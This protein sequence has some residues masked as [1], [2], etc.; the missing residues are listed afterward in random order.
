MQREGEFPPT[1]P[2]VTM[3]PSIRLLIAASFVISPLSLAQERESRTPE[4]ERPN[5]ERPV[6]P[7]PRGERPRQV[8][9]RPPGPPQGDP[10]GMMMRQMEAVQGMMREQAARMERAQRERD[11][12]MAAMVREMDARL[13]RLEGAAKSGQARAETKPNA[14]QDKHAERVR[15]AMEALEAKA[16]S[17]KEREAEMVKKN[18]AL[19]R[20]LVV[21]KSELQRREAV[22]KAKER[23]LEERAKRLAAVEARLREAEKG[24][25]K[26]RREGE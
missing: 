4:R 21:E 17:M 1:E 25:R 12:K 16:R 7:A 5:A 24:A 11:E 23:E 8:D 9:P 26:E 10:Q 15:N 18:E 2:I 14:D 22:L 20:E 3:N 19:A 6:P 13:K